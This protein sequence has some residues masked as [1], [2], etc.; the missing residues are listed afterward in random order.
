M[1]G[2][3]GAYWD[4]TKILSQFERELQELAGDGA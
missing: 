1:L 3:A 2:H 4:K